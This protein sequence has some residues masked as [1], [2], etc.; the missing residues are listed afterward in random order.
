MF[1]YKFEVEVYDCIFSQVKVTERKE[2]YNVQY[3]YNILTETY[4]FF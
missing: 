4:Y 2:R 1:R 3:T